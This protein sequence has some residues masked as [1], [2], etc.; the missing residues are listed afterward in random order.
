MTA[1]PALLKA[2]LFTP[3]SCTNAVDCGSVM[4]FR[5]LLSNGC[6][7]EDVAA[8]A[9]RLAAVS[10]RGASMDSATEAAGSVIGLA[11]AAQWG[12]LTFRPRLRWHVGRRKTDAGFVSEQSVAEVACD[13][14]AVDA[15]PEKVLWI[16]DGE[17]RHI[18]HVSDARQM[19]RR[20]GQ[21]SLCGCA[22]ALP[23]AR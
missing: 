19:A 4:N 12:P 14:A 16:S 5:H 7:P 10:R 23:T 15:G 22:V 17:N 2:I 18:R 3:W 6:G 9:A 20:R 11:L 21:L 13:E 1:S 8:D